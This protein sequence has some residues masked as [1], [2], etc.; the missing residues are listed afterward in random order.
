[1]ERTAAG[2]FANAVAA[3]LWEEEDMG[4]RCQNAAFPLTTLFRLRREAIIKNTRAPIAAG[5]VPRPWTSSLS[6]PSSL[7]TLARRPFGPR[8]ARVTH[9]RPTLFAGGGRRI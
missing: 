5:Q 8:S 4:K 7:A 1:M 6:L 3:E 9:C 2:L